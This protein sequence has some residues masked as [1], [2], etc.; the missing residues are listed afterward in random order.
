MPNRRPLPAHGRIRDHQA[1]MPS[2]VLNFRLLGHAPTHMPMLS[3]EMLAR[4][5]IE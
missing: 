4:T 5:Q 2:A 3:D 1:L